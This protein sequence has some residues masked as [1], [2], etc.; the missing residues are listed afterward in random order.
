M[1]NQSVF[2]GKKGL[3]FGVLG[4]GKLFMEEYGVLAQGN[5]VHLSTRI[6][7]DSHRLGPIMRGHLKMCMECC[8]SI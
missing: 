7:F 8:L 6:Y 2:S 1:G 4:F 5:G 3:S